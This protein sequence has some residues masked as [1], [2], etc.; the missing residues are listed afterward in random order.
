MNLEDVQKQFARAIQSRAALPQAEARLAIYREQ[1]ARRHLSS[2]KDDYLSVCHLLGDLAFTEFARDYLEVFPPTHFSL[3][4]LGLAMPDFVRGSSTWNPIPRLRDL[5]D[6]ERAYLY[7]FD[8]KDAL[9]VTAD[10]IAQIPEQAWPGVRLVFHPSMTVLDLGFD[11]VQVRNRVRLGESLADILREETTSTEA[12][13]FAIGRRQDDALIHLA[14]ELA[15]AGFLGLLQQGLT[16]A[17]ASAKTPNMDESALGRWFA[18]WSSCGWIS[19]LM[20]SQ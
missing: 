19:V 13:A 15:E 18:K 14:L 1:F 4:P 16:L 3:Q 20:Q 2:L 6:V 10:G 11:A 9:P 7:A 17:E 12:C 8:A 5:V